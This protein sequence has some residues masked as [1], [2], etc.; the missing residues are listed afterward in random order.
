MKRQ[1]AE[2]IYVRSIRSKYLYFVFFP[3]FLSVCFASILHYNLTRGFSYLSMLF[4]LI[5]YMSALIHFIHNF[6]L[7]GFEF[8]IHFEHSVLTFDKTMELRACDFTLTVASTTRLFVAYGLYC[9][10]FLLLFLK[11]FVGAFF[12]PIGFSSIVRCERVRALPKA[13]FSSSSSV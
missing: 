2:R 5:Q 4:P 11:I 6:V 3:F 13:F 9:I 12:F 7:Y 8:L 1:E 10:L